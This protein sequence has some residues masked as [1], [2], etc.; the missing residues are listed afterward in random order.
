MFQDETAR[1][2]AEHIFEPRLLL[3][4][5]GFLLFVVAVGYA[6]WRVLVRLP[7]FPY[8]REMLWGARWTW[9][10]MAVALGLALAV[11]YYGGAY[12]GYPLT[13]III[14]QAV[15]VVG[16]ADTTLLLPMRAEGWRFCLV[17][18]GAR[19]RGQRLDLNAWVT[20]RVRQHHKP[21][22]RYGLGVGGSLAVLLM[23]A[24]LVLAFTYPFDRDV[25]RVD[26]EQRIAN[27]V[28]A[29]VREHLQGQTVVEVRAY[30]PIDLD[31]LEEAGT[32]SQAKGSLREILALDDPPPLEKPFHLFIEVAPDTSVEDAEVVLEQARSALKERHESRQWQ[33]SVV[34][35]AEM[36]REASTPDPR[37]T[38]EEVETRE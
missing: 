24:Y 17:A 19:L 10:V 12:T 13:C 5:A 21:W 33:V 36:L 14:G 25:A 4:Y 38:T 32:A 20:A 2:V 23:N 11:M 7:D 26:R 15:F 30:G 22:L 9:A 27:E 6:S 3:V 18:L 34:R 31:W 37:S 29:D 35:G 16:V 1:M 28:A 8:R